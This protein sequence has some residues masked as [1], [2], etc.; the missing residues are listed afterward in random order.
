MK[1]CISSSGNNLEA[2]VDPRFGRCLYFIFLDDKNPDDFKAVQNAGVRA[3]RG[4]GIQAAQTVVNE[5]AESVITGN[6]GPNAF[7]ALNSSGIRIFQAPSGIKAKQALE[8]FKNNNLQ[9]LAQP[10]G[11]FGSGGRGRGFSRGRR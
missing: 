3:M 11:G 4:A 7:G 2:A 10:F 6:V 9:E 5:K 1:I 8:E